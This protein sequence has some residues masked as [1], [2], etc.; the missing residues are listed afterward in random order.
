MERLSNTV[1]PIADVTPVS[2]GLCSGQIMVICVICQVP[3]IG[4]YL[5]SPL[6]E[7]I[8][9][10]HPKV[11]AC[12]WCGQFGKL[13]SDSCAPCT[14]SGV[15]TD[16]ELQALA[17]PVL[18]WLKQQIGTHQ[19]DQATLQISDAKALQGTQYA[20]TRWVQDHAGFRA[21]I[22]V[23]AGIP[24]LNAKE[25]LAHEYGHLLLVAEPSTMT[26]IGPHGLSGEEEEGFCEVIRA[27]WIDRD[28]GAR[29][30][31]RRT[32]LETNAIDMYRNGF[33]Q[34]WPRYTAAASISRFRDAVLSKSGTSAPS[35]R[36]DVIRPRTTIPVLGATR[37][38]GPRAP[39]EA[40][41]RG[42]R[43]VIATRTKRR[44]G[45]DG[46]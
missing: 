6:G 30:H 35:I 7:T 14:S 29:R 8:C 27:L 37:N 12:R 21:A 33:A 28:A 20:E 2:N 17:G 10:A 15:R 13:T 3:I 22:D 41:G 23:V 32:L 36:S 9:G 40:R 44:N 16:G 26:Y 11:S 34:M 19:L 31:E 4:R 42:H 5:I 18:T 25:A 45:L 1:N 43:P 46:C 24:Q 38:T 39:V